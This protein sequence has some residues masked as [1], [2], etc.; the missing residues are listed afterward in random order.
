MGADLYT[1]MGH[2]TVGI[3]L[4]KFFVHFLSLYIGVLYAYVLLEYLT[5]VC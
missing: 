4:L 3:L 5:F 2:L 1:K